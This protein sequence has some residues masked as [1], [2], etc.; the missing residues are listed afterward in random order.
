MILQENQIQSSYAARNKGIHFSSGEIICFTDVDCRPES[1]WVSALVKPFVDPT[2]VLVGGAIISLPGTTLMEKY[3]E[4][5][6]ILSHEQLLS[7]SV[8][9]YIQT[10]NLALRKKILETTGLFRPYLTTGGDAD[11]C[12]RIQQVNSSKLYCAEEAVVKHRHRKTFKGLLSQWRRYGRGHQYL[13]ELHDIELQN[14]L[15]WN[16]QKYFY[17][18]KNWLLK[19][20]PRQIIK[21][22]IGRAS[23]LDLLNTP[24]NLLTIQARVSERRRTELPEQA[25]QIEWL[26]Q[27]Q[28]ELSDQSVS[29]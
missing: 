22:M 4:R 2:V 5:R 7:R 18:W 21:L 25:R 16:W 13:K 27:S 17:H 23:L 14:D 1:D 3:A 15:S 28:N 6:K 10:A 26:S 8:Y 9:P 29:V 19:E 11:I 12:W 24:I 20:F